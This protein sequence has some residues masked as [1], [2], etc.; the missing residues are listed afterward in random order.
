MEK[1]GTLRTRGDRVYS[2][3]G[4]SSSSCFSESFCKRIVVNLKFSDLLRSD[5]N[6]VKLA[7]RAGQG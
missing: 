3:F 5:D 7:I 6:G 2:L 1:R 4:T